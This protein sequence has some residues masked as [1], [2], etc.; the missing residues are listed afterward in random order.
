MIAR[1]KNAFCRPVSGGCRKQCLLR[2]GLHED[3][4]DADTVHCLSLFLNAGLQ[5]LGAGN[6]AVD[7]VDQLADA[8]G[9]K[10][11]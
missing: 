6:G 4:L 2:T 11:R 10:R 9:F 1:G 8:V 3:Q 5:K 7:R